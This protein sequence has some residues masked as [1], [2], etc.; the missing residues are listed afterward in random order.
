MSRDAEEGKG[1]EVVDPEM[2][3]PYAVSKARELY[4]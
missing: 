4:I 2:L 1:I 3:D